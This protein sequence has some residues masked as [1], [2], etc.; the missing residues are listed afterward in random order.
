MLMGDILH[1]LERNYVNQK[2]D[3]EIVASPP[4]GINFTKLFDAER[5]A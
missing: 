1:P 5:F 2:P 3:R 4:V